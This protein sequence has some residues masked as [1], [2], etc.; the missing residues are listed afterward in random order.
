MQSGDDQARD[1]R[2]AATAP[3]RGVLASAERLQGWLSRNS[4]NGMLLGPAAA[5]LA[6]TGAALLGW[7]GLLAAALLIAFMSAASSQIPADSWLSLYRTEPVAPGQAQ[8]LR[9]A[10][11]N[12][13]DRAGLLQEPA[14]AIIPS[15]SIG[16]FRVGTGARTAILMTEGLLRRLTLRDLA[17]LAAHEI[18]HIRAG[19]LKVFALAD[20]MVRVA[21]ALFYCGL[22]LGALNI[23]LW[24]MGERF[25]DL[26]P[27]GLLLAAPALN[28]ALQ[29]AL[30]RE[31]DFAADKAAVF[32]LG[33]H[34]VVVKAAEGDNHG[35]LSDDVRLPVPQRRI[36]LPSPLRCAPGAA[37]REAALEAGRPA[38][39]LPPLQVPDEPMI[40][41]LGFGPIEMR[42]RDRWPGLWF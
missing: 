6:L 14:L 32:L 27:I 5:Y 30:P 18:G 8:G 16:V 37:R 15:L 1:N 2:P 12:L 42:P 38:V 19:H 22:A 26:L 3:A 40:S 7:P 9:L 29:L 35:S 31:H 25:V 21:Q 34:D 17:A 23:V 11:A 39:L 36:P 28:A 24:V 4:W 41:L 33:S 13:S 20:V 10:I